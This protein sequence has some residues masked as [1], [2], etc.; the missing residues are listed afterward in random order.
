MKTGKLTCIFAILIIALC[1]MSATAYADDG[2]I[3]SWAQLQA[4]IDAAATG[5]T[6]TLTEDLTATSEDT[7]LRAMSA[8]APPTAPKYTA[9]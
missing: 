1:V 6:I 3:T 9:P 4:A 8:A 2:D 7:M 5:E